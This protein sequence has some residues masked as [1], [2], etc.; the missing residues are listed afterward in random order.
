MNLACLARVSLALNVLALMSGC[1]TA[2]TRDPAPITRHTYALAVAVSGGKKPTPA[3]WAT[4]EAGF[5]KII[6]PPGRLIRDVASAD[7]V[8]HVS[9]SPGA[10]DLTGG[11]AT[12]VAVVP[13]PRRPFRYPWDRVIDPETNP[14]AFEL[15]MDALRTP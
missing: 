11:C 6:K 4:L 12:I 14:R 2:P 9:F 5:T 1:A 15:V 7:E 10:A 8:I 3:Q 13:N